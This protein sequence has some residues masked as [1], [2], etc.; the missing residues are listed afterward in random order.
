MTD[1]ND[2]S[3][4]P[5]KVVGNF[6]CGAFW[7]S[8]M[9]LEKLFITGILRKLIGLESPIELW[10]CKPDPELR[11]NPQEPQIDQKTKRIY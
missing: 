2:R 9:I 10:I 7:A 5:S 11:V 6:H 1:Q 3:K 4:W 8:W